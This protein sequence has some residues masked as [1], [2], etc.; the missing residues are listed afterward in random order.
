MLF[1]TVSQCEPVHARSIFPCQDTP[2]VKS[3]FDIHVHSIFPV[4]ASG[5]PAQDP[6]YH[7]VKGT[8]ESKI[9]TFIQ[10]IP[11]SNYLFS[12]A[13][14]YDFL[15]QGL[16]CLISNA[17]NLEISSVTKLVPEA[18]SIALRVIWTHARQSYSQ[19]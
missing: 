13:S 11:I 15:L 16:W 18:T 6:I 14:G 10:D 8:P 9:Y 3:T 7:A 17:W 1:V 5:C 2:F 19:I 12:V 4:V